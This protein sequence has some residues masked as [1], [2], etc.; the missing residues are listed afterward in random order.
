MGLAYMAG[1]LYF[2]VL[3]L[4]FTWLSAEDSQYPFT[5]EEMQRFGFP[6]R[7]TRLSA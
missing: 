4:N 7:A 6:D 5:P 2:G 3:K 1:F